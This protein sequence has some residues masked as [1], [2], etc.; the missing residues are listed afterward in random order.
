MEVLLSPN[1]AIDILTV[2]LSKTLVGGTWQ[3]TDLNGK[4]VLGADVPHDAQSFDVGLQSIAG[5]IYFLQLKEK[6]A[7]VAVRKFVVL[8]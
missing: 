7:L 6:N 5:G 8:R 3:I 2:F 4:A 1:P